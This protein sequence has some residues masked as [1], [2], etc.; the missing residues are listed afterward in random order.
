LYGIGAQAQQTISLPGPFTGA[1]VDIAGLLKI[2]VDTTIGH[3]P[4]PLFTWANGQADVIYGG[5]GDDW[6]HGGAGDDAV[7]GAEALPQFYHDTRPLP[8]APFQFNRDQ[9]INNWL[10]P[11]DG[12][13]YLFSD[14]ANP[15]S[16][17]I[18]PGGDDFIL[19]FDSFDSSGTL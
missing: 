17:I 8:A 6:L 12:Q 19:N 18:T 1:V 4:D 5:L 7:S 14:S 10:N 15:L 13:Q 9:S 11:L 2:T 3:H 16:K